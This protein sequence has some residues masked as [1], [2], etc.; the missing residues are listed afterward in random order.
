METIFGFENEGP[1]I[2]DLGKVVTREGRLLTFPNVMQHRV[3]PFR[4]ADPTR[5]GHRKILALFLVD[6][7]LRIIS[8]A[9][10]PPQQKAWWRELVEDKGALKRVPREIADSILD[11]TDFPVALEKAKLQRLELMDERKKFV[12]AHNDKYESLNVFSLCEH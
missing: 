4:L 3:Y 8:T 10:V 2:Q 7:H 5:P 1:T 12:V 9:N 6:P 11:K